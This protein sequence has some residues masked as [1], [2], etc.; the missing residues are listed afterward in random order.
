M[1]GI[2]G[3]SMLIV[4]TDILACPRCGPEF[5]LLVM[6]ERLE[7][8]RVVEGSLGCANCRQLY[9]I[10]AGLA[11]LRYPPA[12]G[13]P[14][15]P[16]EPVPVVDAEEEA[17]RTAALLGVT[18]GPGVLLMAGPATVMARAVAAI[19][20]EVGIVSVGPEAAELADHE[21]G[22]RVLSVASLPFR[23][24][25]VRGV[26]LTGWAASE[27]LEEGVRTAAP[28]ARLVLD[29]APNDCAD[30]LAAAGATLL[31]LQDGIAVASV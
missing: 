20:P 22:S 5:G 7:D 25:S 18:G 21:G 15:T 6:A 14:D 4:L 19:V 30:R 2:R 29:P 28:G 12:M 27:L 10:R 9:P 31:L 17:L 16:A 23:T 24:G 11:D 1:A 8:R 3:C 13:P 26:A